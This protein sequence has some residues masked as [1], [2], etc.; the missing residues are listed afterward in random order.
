MWAV[1]ARESGGPD[2]LEWT[3]VADPSPGPAEILVRVHAAGVNYIDTYRRSGVYPTPF[4]HIPGVEGSGE[5][6]RAGEGAP[7]ALG[8]RV[9]W[10]SAPGSYAELAVVPAAEALRVP[11]DVDLD[12]AAALPLQ[13]LTAHYLVRS[14]FPVEAGTTMLLTAGAG[15][16]GQLAVQLAKARGATVI[17]TVGSESKAAVARE[18]G[19]DHVLVTDGMDL[20]VDLPPAVRALVPEGVDVSY[21]GV[22]RD[23]F[24]ATLAC[25]RPRGM[26]VL[27]GGASGQVPP[28]DLQRLNALGSLY[29]TRPSLGHY[30]AT[31]DELDWRADELFELV[32]RGAMRVRIGLREEL[33]AARVA[34]EALEGRATTGKVILTA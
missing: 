21:D 3:E 10:F 6:V 27:F 30:V 1:L 4:P 20:P 33:A 26:Q 28:F 13:G 8:D 22:G 34:H 23:T 24:D 7:F 18:A 25:L 14:T 12:T 5:V 31:R 17:T 32:R 16:V 9:A 11:D 15:G 29:V 2:V 19:A